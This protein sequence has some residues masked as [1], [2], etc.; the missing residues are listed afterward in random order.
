MKGSV[1][2]DVGTV[3]IAA[4]LFMVLAFAVTLGVGLALKLLH[5]VG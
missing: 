1:A 4:M 2:E 5:L 3:V